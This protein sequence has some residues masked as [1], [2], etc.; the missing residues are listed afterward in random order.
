M[1]TKRFIFHIAHFTTGYSECL[2]EMDSWETFIPLSSKS[3]NR[4]GRIFLTII[5]LSA[6]ILI[7][8]GYDLKEKANFRCNPNKT[9]A[10]DLVAKNFVETNCY[11]EYERIHHPSVPVSRFVVINFGLMLVISV[12][13][14]GLVNSKVETFLSKSPQNGDENDQESWLKERSQETNIFI[15]P[16]YILHLILG[17][18]VP[19]I[20]YFLLIYPANFPM[21]FQCQ[22]NDE[23]IVECVNPLGE[24]F[25]TLATSALIIDCIIGTLGFMEVGYLLY[26]FS[27][28]SDFASDV[29][30]CSMYVLEKRNLTIRQILKRIRKTVRKN[31]QFRYV[32]SPFHPSG[33]LLGDLNFRFLAYEVIE[34][35][36]QKHEIYNV[37]LKQDQ[38]S[39]KNP[40][41]HLFP[42][43]HVQ[44]VIGNN[45]NHT[46]NTDDPNT[47]TDP[48]TH[49]SQILK[50]CDKI[51]ITGRAGIGKTTATKAILYRWATCS[52]LEDKVVIF[53]RFREFRKNKL[54]TLK[55]MLRQGEGIPSG[56]NFEE[57]FKFILVNPKK[58]VLIFDGL[59]DIQID[60]DHC[61]EELDED[62]VNDYQGTMSMFAI[63]L[64]L[65]KNKFLPG[66]T[67]ITSSRPYKAEKMCNFL[68]VTFQTR[69][70]LLGFTKNDIKDYVRAFCQAR[71]ESGNVWRTIESNAE[72]LS[73]CY[74]PA[75]CDLVCLILNECF[76]K[77]NTENDIEKYIPKT[78]TELYQRAIRV[79]V[80]KQLK[81]KSF[82]TRGYLISS[83]PQSPENF[84]KKLKKIAKSEME[85][86]ETS[87]QLEAED[88]SQNII[89]CGLLT[90]LPDEYYCFLHT[91]MKEFLA[92][93]HIVDGMKD[94][95][96]VRQ[97]LSSFKNYLEKPHWHLVVQFVA[98]LL[99][100]KIRQKSIDV[101]KENICRSFLQLIRPLTMPNSKMIDKSAA[102]LV[103]KCL[104][105]M[106]DKEMV[107]LCANEVDGGGNKAIFNLS[108]LNIAPVD[109]TALFQFL[110]HVKNL[111]KLNVSNN[112]ISD[113][114]C[115]GLA[116]FINEKVNLTL[117][118]L[119][120]ISL[121]DEGIRIICDKIDT[122]THRIISLILE[123]N[124]IKAAG[125][126]CLSDAMIGKKLN[127]NLLDLR[128][129]KIFYEGAEALSRALI[130]PNC[131][132]TK[133]NLSGGQIGN[134]GVAVLCEALQHKN[135][136]L[137]DI[138]LSGN[139]INREGVKSLC[140]VLQI[141]KCKVTS[142][143][144]QRN[145]LKAHDIEPIRDVLLSKICTLTKLDLGVNELADVGV[146]CIFPG[147]IE[148]NICK[149]VHLSLANNKIKNHGV[150]TVCNALMNENCKLTL[151]DL[152]C[153]EIGKIGVEHLSKALKNQNCKINQLNL[154]NNNMTKQDIQKLRS[155]HG[156][157]VIIH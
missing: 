51:L 3:Y 42:D 36:S 91:T 19:I 150:E 80:S 111:T 112:Q 157:L 86:T 116:K 155:R 94:I 21:K 145:G 57:L 141:G 28:D 55:M 62:T 82:G 61:L 117:L 54:T 106:Q 77:S 73:L 58:V 69:L 90:R 84:M 63:Y 26:I 130:H 12:L 60:W 119:T 37:H 74:T 22:W 14:V 101:P 68:K 70:E 39:T 144:L 25:T 16:L 66:A 53:L 99:G 120:R 118:N 127:L 11:I 88:I 154:L 147:L 38:A 31:E 140:D 137:V 76:E 43:E 153:N 122:K 89:S 104:H 52:F 29:E 65:L 56:T 7:G 139:N 48:I 67:I 35:S 108:G 24:K 92:A 142:L 129:N 8:V 27:Q 96:D 47:T 143:V 98:G 109:C 9:I 97:F 20:L 100:E 133:L 41:L 121:S 15:F 59:D 40:L 95:C 107:K 30:F 156:R 5:F 4:N 124:Q 138:C 34:R 50:I 49:Y 125:V 149:L 136:K 128:S 18:I 17:R 72:F 105:E 114:G 32:M 134:E 64:K 33:Q 6:V 131:N 46:S 113:L 152:S 85:S 23:T 78:M 81:F 75:T 87:F 13:Y 103:I 110:I 135:C 83:L 44:I 45:D 115:H 148:E 2:K 146:E 123:I 151:L 132:L 10:A 93:Y 102:L 126:K 1:F 71:H 79:I